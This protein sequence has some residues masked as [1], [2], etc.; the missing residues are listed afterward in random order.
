VW[1]A[2]SATG[3]VPPLYHFRNVG[4]SSQ[5]PVVS[6]KKQ[7]QH[8][9][10]PNLLRVQTQG[11]I[12]PL[13][14]P[15][16]WRRSCPAELSGME[17]LLTHFGRVHDGR[18]L[19]MLVRLTERMMSLNYPPCK[20]SQWHGVRRGW[21]V[22]PLELGCHCHARGEMYMI[23]E[24]AFTSTPSPSASQTRPPTVDYW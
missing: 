20:L 23:V 7:L 24:P 15:S 3:A 17:S 10:N 2:S 6:T 18:V 22:R 21:V 9:Y 4:D 19:S 8:Y 5:L 11:L 14:P 12:Q 16:S 1:S 13:F